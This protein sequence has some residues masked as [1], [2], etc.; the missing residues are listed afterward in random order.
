VSRIEIIPNICTAANM[1]LGVTA[2]A[3]VLDH[4]YHLSVILILLAAFTD[5]IDGILARHCNAVS[6]FGKEF[7][8]LA[9][10]I[11]FGV[12]PAVLLYSSMSNKWNLAGLVC[13]GVF[14][15]CGGLRLARFNIS[16]NPYFFQGVPIT[17]AGSI[18]AIIIFLVH[19]PAIIMVSGFILALA[20]ISTVR[21]PK[22]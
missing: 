5:R 4:N 21:I 20:M 14:T 3:K 15:L 11:S 9:D 10:L 16:S 12:A 7:D 13:F 17:V 18:L 19:N 22:I 1:L 6:A 8:S 2:I